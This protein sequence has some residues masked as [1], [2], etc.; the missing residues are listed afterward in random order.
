MR[1]GPRTDRPA[2]DRAR[3]RHHASPVSITDPDYQAKVARLGARVKAS[4]M[5]HAIRHHIRLHADEDPVR[6]APV[7]GPGADLAE[8]AATGNSSRSP[9]PPCFKR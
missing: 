7:R 9:S 4:E 6:Y 2:H 5:E 1:E 3:R 8:H